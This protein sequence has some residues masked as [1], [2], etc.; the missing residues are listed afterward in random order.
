MNRQH[1]P[2]TDGR[3][4]GELDPQSRRADIVGSPPE[5]PC[6]IHIQHFDRPILSDPQPSAALGRGGIIGF[7]WFL[8]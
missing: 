8:Q 3:R 5:I 4:P 1:L 2:I 6:P 7:N